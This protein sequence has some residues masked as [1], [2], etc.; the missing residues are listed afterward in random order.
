MFAGAGELYANNDNGRSEALPRCCS[1][2]SSAWRPTPSSATWWPTAWP[3]TSAKPQGTDNLFKLADATE[4]AAMTIF[5]S[6]GISSVIQVLSGGLIPGFGGRPGHR[7]AAVEVTV[8]GASLWLVQ[9]QPAEEIAATWDF[10]QYLV[11]A[12]TQSDWANGTGYVP[13]NE[14]RRRPTP[15]PTIPGSGC[16]TTSW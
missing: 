8:G 4:P 13:I 5:T 15:T 16:R 10:I 2:T 12:Q 14:R 7:A 11:S 1:T 3:S 9:D 6:A